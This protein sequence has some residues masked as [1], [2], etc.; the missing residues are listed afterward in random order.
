MST[1]QLRAAVREYAASRPPAEGWDR[2]DD[3]DDRDIDLTVAG[4]ASVMGAVHRCRE[5]IG[6]TVTFG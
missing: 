6:A 2:L 3:W 1:E 4:V 5:A